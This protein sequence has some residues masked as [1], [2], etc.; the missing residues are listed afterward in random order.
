MW[1]FESP[2]RIIF[3]FIAV[4]MLVA[5]LFWLYL[6]IYAAMQVRAENADIQLSHSL[7][8][9]I[10]VG[11]YLQ[12]QSIGKL[13]TQIALDRKLQLPLQGKYLADLQFSVEVPISVDIDYT[14]K[15]QINQTM[16]LEA[17]SDL[18]FKNKLLPKY[19]LKMDIPVKLDVPFHLK[20]TYNI[21]IRINFNGPVYFEFNEKVD[22]HVVH[23][24]APQLNLNDPMT[25]RKIASF[26]A[27]MYN[28]ERHSKANLNMQMS[29]PLKSIRP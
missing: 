27:T 19:P 21:P 12:T 14:T 1:I 3:S 6:N 26:N 17:S 18:V 2:K 15:I 11:N 9:K 28:A 20:R 10:S 5:I 22:L 7:P 24:F 29:L 16:P 25:M 4:V 13:D 8:T 23:Q